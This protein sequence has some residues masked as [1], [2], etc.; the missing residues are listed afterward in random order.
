MPVEAMIY[1]EITA[2]FANLNTLI[3]KHT[4]E[5][6][7]RVAARLA[8]LIYFLFPDLTCHHRGLQ[9]LWMQARWMKARLV[10]SLTGVQL[11]TI[12]RL[13]DP[14]ISNLGHQFI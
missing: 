10:L 5:Q 1:W 2:G 13:S 9:R 8:E 14:F 12:T 7:W 3:C 4:A 6:A 11:V